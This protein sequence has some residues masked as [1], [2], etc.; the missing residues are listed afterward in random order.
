[1]D[2]EQGMEKRENRPLLKARVIEGPTVV[3]GPDQ[4]EFCAGEAMEISMS[5]TGRTQNLQWELE[6]KDGFI[7]LAENEIYQGVRT[8]TLRI[9]SDPNQVLDTFVLRLKLA[10]ECGRILTSQ[11]IRVSVLDV[12][13]AAFSFEIEGLTVLFMNEANDLDSVIWD[14]GDGTISEKEN[15]SHVFE[16]GGIYQ[17]MQLVYSECGTDTLIRK[18]VLGR[19]PQ[20][21]YTLKSEKGC[22]PLAVGFFDQSEG[23]VNQWFWRFP[24]GNPA[25]SN[26]RS[27]QVLFDTPGVYSAELVVGNTVGYDTL[28]LENVVEVF[29]PPVVDFTA[30]WIDGQLELKN[31]TTGATQY[32]WDFGDGNEST[33]FEP[34]HQY[35]KE[36]VYMVTLM[37]LNEA[38]SRTLS[39]EIN[40]VI[41]NLDRVQ[42]DFKLAIYPNPVQEVCIVELSEGDLFQKALL[43]DL[44]GNVIQQFFLHEGTNILKIKRFS[45]GIYFLRLLGVG[46]AFTHKLLLLNP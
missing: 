13:K 2:G 8:P 35:L 33:S 11:P 22:A 39:K 14:F 6:T 25:L 42:D 24:G 36:G 34:V 1:M 43:L 15:P 17:V 29:E 45:G 16:N 23:E 28:W 4:L 5:I 32:K 38:C 44:N 46:G 37:A 27:V 31:Q 40:I 26:D 9:A 21:G 30:E 18:V 41:T 20:A 3:T 10:D 7:E 19:L 12:K